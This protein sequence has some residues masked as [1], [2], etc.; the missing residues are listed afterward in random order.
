M[1]NVI[2]YRLYKYSKKFILRYLANLKVKRN[3]LLHFKQ[4]F[5]TTIG[6]QIRQYNQL[7]SYY[8]NKKTIDRNTD[9]AIPLEK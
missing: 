5:K 2:R 9:L 7:A 6:K 8:L 4:K 1:N 3:N